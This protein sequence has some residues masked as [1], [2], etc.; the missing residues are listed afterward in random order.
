LVKENSLATMEVSVQ[1]SEKNIEIELPRDQPYHFWV[2]IPNNKIHFI[3]KKCVVVTAL[4][5][6]PIHGTSLGWMND[7]LL[8][9]MAYDQFV[10]ICHHLHALSL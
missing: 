7:I 1:V 9:L 10:A 5:T 2:Y 6:I 8:N 4:F 3:I